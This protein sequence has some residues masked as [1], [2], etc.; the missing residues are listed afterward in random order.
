MA[1]QKETWLKR[2]ALHTLG[3]TMYGSGII[4]LALFGYGLIERQVTDTNLR[5][6]DQAIM[7]AYT[8]DEPHE[9]AAFREFAI[10]HYDGEAQARENTKYEMAAGLLAIP[11]L[12]AETKRV[13]KI[14][15]ESPGYKRFIS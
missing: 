15:A 1:E 9:L 12:V 3:D 5:N 2:T 14:I 4:G 11:A 8:T 10:N 7:T 13:R 6:Y